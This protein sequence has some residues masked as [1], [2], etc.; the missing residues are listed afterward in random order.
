MHFKGVL[1]VC[2]RY[3]F[4][5]WDTYQPDALCLREQGYEDP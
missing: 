3:K 1:L 2:M 5:I 4:L